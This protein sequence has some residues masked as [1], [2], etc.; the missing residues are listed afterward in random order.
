MRRVLAELGWQDAWL[1]KF[2]VSVA[3]ERCD[4]LFYCKSR[5]L[6]ATVPLSSCF[7]W[8][9]HGLGRFGDCATD[10]TP[11][12][13]PP[14]RDQ[15]KKS[16]RPIIRARLYAATLL[17]AR[18]AQCIVWEVQAPRRKRERREVP[19]GKALPALH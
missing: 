11:A 12:P 15:R 13:P 4:A 3:V 6:I 10:D 9:P 5:N 1:T 18:G 14:A 2:N 16:S 8:S 7:V 19:H 17:T